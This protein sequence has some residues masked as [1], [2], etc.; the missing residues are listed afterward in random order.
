LFRSRSDGNVAAMRP[1][2]ATTI[3][4]ALTASLCGGATFAQAPATPQPPLQPPLV[5]PLTVYPKTE[6]PKIVRSYPAAGQ[7]LSAG[8]LVL[9]VTFDQPMLKTGFDFAA[10]AGGEAPRCLKTPRLL[11]DT[12]T[13]VLLC[14]TE[15]K[16][17]YTLAFNARPQGGFE[18]VAEHRADPA[19]LAF[20][21][22]DGDGPR[23]I[24]SAMKAASLT[25]LDMPIQDTP[26]HP[27]ETPKP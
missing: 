13:F 17:A 3:A 22:T 18:N 27:P 7:A 16:K 8:V 1:L 14:T 26:E 15:P 6:A 25:P 20:S 23:D 10:S 12:K 2:A 24:Q 9:S 5:S 21:T 11:N 4:L 19:T